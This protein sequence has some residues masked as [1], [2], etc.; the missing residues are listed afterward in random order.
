M[1]RGF[2]S[3]AVADH[4][5]VPGSYSSAESSSP[6]GLKPPTTRTR[7]SCSVV[8]VWLLRAVF[9]DPVADHVWVSGS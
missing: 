1:V 6:S 3:G 8:E 4:A 9:S 7:P 2:P 5:P